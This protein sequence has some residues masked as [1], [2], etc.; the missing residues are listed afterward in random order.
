MTGYA[1][2]LNYRYASFGV[3]A[4]FMNP[5]TDRPAKLR[6]I[7]MT[8]G[9]TVGQEFAQVPTV[10]PIATARMEELTA[11]D[12]EPRDLVDL[13]ITLNGA[14]WQVRSYAPH[15]GP[16]GAGLGQIYFMLEEPAE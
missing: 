11:L 1:R 9:I 3:D 8:K 6:M 4:T 5:L 13:V 16:F 10:Q 7:D 2:I 12:L 14:R 15:P